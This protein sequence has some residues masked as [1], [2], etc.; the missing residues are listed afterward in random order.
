MKLLFLFAFGLAA[1][2]I[3][4]SQ[5][6]NKFALFFVTWFSAAFFNMILFYSNY[7]I[8]VKILAYVIG[9]AL[10]LV[11]ISFLLYLIISRK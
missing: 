2:F 11:A 7:S 10:P 8:T 5:L 3:F 4:R 6:K 1:P 9:E